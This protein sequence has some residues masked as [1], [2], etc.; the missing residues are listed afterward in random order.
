MRFDDVGIVTVRENCYRIVFQGMTKGES[1][2]KI[3]N[4]KTIR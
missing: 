2:S 1:V 3:K 4:Q